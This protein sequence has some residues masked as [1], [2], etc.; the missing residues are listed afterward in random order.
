MPTSKK[1]DNNWYYIMIY[2]IVNFIR[3]FSATHSNELSITFIF[4]VEN[5][6]LEIP[7]PKTVLN[8]S[9]IP[10]QGK[11]S[12]DPVSKVLIWDIGRIDTSKLPNLRGAVTI[13]NIYR[14]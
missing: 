8:C 10:N 6:S 7:M 12:F 9:L 3:Y 2:L 1:N 14:V 11:Y 4:Q 5:V 13:K